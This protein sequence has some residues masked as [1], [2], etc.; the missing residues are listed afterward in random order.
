MKKALIITSIASDTNQILKKYAEKA[1]EKSISFIVVGDLKSPN[2]F[3]IPGCHFLSIEEQEQQDFSL[4]S[5]LPFNSYSRKNIGYLAALKEGAEVIIET[6]DDN[7][8]LDNFFETRVALHDAS[9]LVNSGWV[10]VYRYFS[11]MQIWPRGFPLELISSDI[12]KLPEPKKVFSP[13]LQGLADGDPD[14]DAIFRLTKPILME[15]KKN[16]PIALGENSMCP[17]NSQNTTWHQ[18]AFPLLYLP[19]YC[20]FRMT[21]IWRSF[22]AQ[23]ILW[24]CDW[25]IS[26]HQSTVYQERNAHDLMRDF[27]DEIP[28]Y[29]NNNRIFQLLCD[30]T[31]KKGKGYIF[32][33]LRECYRV[34][35]REKLIGEQELKLVDLWIDDILAIQAHAN[36]E[37]F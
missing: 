36:K 2:K 3:F 12:P 14:V 16:P 24:T 21:D 29:L 35:V 20:N 7:L 26:F 31:L 5:A 23:R 37:I 1:I 8:P 32:D 15:F 6:D 10:N 18:E 30:T 34:L 9:L 19:S 27:E 33:N 28:G 22:I 25:S 4:A 11:D 17:F 13:I